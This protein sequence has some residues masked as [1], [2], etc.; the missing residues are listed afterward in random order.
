MV[1][2]E[3]RSVMVQAAR[4]TTTASGATFPVLTNATVARTYVTPLLPVLF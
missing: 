4:H 3:Q 1:P 2:I